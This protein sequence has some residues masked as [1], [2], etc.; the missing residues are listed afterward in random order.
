MQETPPFGLVEN[1]TGHFMRCIGTS[2]VQ[3]SCG[4][5]TTLRIWETLHIKD[6]G[7]TLKIIIVDQLGR[8]LLGM[9]A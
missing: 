8:T 5:C 9:R 7:S 4:V 2:H 1:V 6:G 3:I